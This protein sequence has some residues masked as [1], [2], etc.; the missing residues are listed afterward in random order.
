MRGNSFSVKNKRDQN[1]LRPT[2]L[3]KLSKVVKSTNK[4]NKIKKS[5]FHFLILFLPM[6]SKVFASNM[7]ERKPKRGPFQ[8]KAATS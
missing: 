5:C 7:L 2:A 6:L 1:E 8:F 4:N 3:V